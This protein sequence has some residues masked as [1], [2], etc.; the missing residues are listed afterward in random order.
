MY[1][2]SNRIINIIGRA[3]DLMSPAAVTNFLYFSSIVYS[4]R[5]ASNETL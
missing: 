4:I 3:D 2:Q 5:Y 1:E